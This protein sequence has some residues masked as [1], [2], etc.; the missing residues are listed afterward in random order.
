MLFNLVFKCYN[1]SIML[2]YRFLVLNLGF[3][4]FR[5]VFVFLNLDFWVFCDVDRDHVLGDRDQHAD[6]RLTMN[7]GLG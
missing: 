4:V 5:A 2:G 1:V 6:L 7:L 3:E